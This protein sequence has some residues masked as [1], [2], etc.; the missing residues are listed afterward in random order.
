MN[1]ENR[2]ISQTTHIICAKCGNNIILDNRYDSDILIFEDMNN[3]K[4]NQLSFNY[5]CCKEQYDLPC[6]LIRY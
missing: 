4:Y 3:D 1:K 6:K 2:P 5:P